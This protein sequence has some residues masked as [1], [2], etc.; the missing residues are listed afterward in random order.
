MDTAYTVWMC[1]VID[2]RYDECL[3][4]TYHLAHEG[5]SRTVCGLAAVERQTQCTVWSVA[6][7][8]SYQAEH[9]TCKRCRKLAGV[10]TRPGH[11]SK[12]ML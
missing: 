10:E 7:D 2:R 9:A 5:A 6:V 8:H 4:G 3:Y 1:G 12:V 11:E